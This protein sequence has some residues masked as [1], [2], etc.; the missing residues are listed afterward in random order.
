[1]CEGPIH[2]DW[3]LSW[4][5]GPGWS[6]NVGWGSEQVT[7][8]HSSMASASAPS[9]KFL[10]WGLALAFLNDGLWSGH[11]T[12]INPFLLNLVL[13]QFFI[14][15]MKN[16][17]RKEWRKNW[18]YLVWVNRHNISGNRL[19]GLSAVVFQGNSS[20]LLFWG[21]VPCCL[22]LIFFAPESQN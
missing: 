2:C 20:R 14:T 9:S 6:R 13:L 3:F 12:Q 17:A 21:L 15:T 19:L 10:P 16:K 1:M 18:Q 11:V 22:V 7:K 5:G 4:S 8:Q